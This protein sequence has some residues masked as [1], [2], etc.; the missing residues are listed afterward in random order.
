M[1]ENNEEVKVMINN[2]DNV[3]GTNKEVKVIIKNVEGMK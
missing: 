1:I 3:K 2:N